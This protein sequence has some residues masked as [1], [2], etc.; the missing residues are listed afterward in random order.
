M[1]SGHIVKCPSMDIEF[2]SCCR[3]WM[4]VVYTMSACWLVSTIH[5]YC[6]RLLFSM[7]RHH[8]SGHGLHGLDVTNDCLM[9]RKVSLFEPDV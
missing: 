9:A 5:V 8:S 1:P 7:H 2:G 4:T 6:Q 3:L